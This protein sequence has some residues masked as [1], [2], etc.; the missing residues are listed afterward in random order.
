[1][2][3]IKQIFKY[4]Q[5]LMSVP[6]VMELIEY[7]NSLEEQVIDDKQIKQF[8]F[9][10]KLTE[11]VREIYIGIKDV[12]RQKEEHI[13]FKYEEPNYEACIENLK[14]YLLDFSKENNF[15]I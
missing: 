4:N 12:D 1:M 13:R 10:D 11:L 6:E 7:C 2:K 15:R 14:R 8:S 3:S 9:E 5:D